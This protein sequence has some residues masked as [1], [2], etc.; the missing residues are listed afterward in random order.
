[1]RPFRIVSV[2]LAGAIMLG[3]FIPQPSGAAKTMPAS[4]FDGS[5]RIVVLADAS[6]DAALVREQ[7]AELLKHVAALDER[8]M[9]VFIAL[10]DGTVEGVHGPAPTPAEVRAFLR[11]NPL[12]NGK[13]AGGF[14]VRLV[15]KDG[16]VKFSS[17]SPVRAEELF[18]LID[19]MPMRRQ[20][21]K[22]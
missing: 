6:A 16:G 8:D 7:R 2:L 17:A 18:A 21:M 22:R 1:M 5:R 4:P 10:P 14:T 9:V 11:R 19:T 12:P 20:E 3:S 13:A 15:G